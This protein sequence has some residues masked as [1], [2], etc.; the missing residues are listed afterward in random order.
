MAAK[1][2]DLDVDILKSKSEALSAELES[3]V[4]SPNTGSCIYFCIAFLFI[5]TRII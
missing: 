3:K 1:N 2:D 4:K 5:K